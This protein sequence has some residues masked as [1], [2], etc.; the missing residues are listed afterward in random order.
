MMALYEVL[1]QFAVV[2]GLLA[3][4]VV[5]NVGLLKQDVAVVLL[6]VQDL[7]NGLNMPHGI[8]SGRGDPVLLVAEA[9]QVERHLPRRRGEG[10]FIGWANAKSFTARAA[11]LGSSPINFTVKNTGR[12]TRGRPVFLVAEAGLE[13]ATSG[14]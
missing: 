9:G 8:P 7:T 3:V 12:P 11:K 2:G 13:P 1:I 6:I 10:G 5:G 4:E 14:L